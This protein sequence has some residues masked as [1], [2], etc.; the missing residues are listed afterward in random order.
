MW[1][2]T[3]SAY[4]YLERGV[5]YRCWNDGAI[6]KTNL[7]KDVLMG[8]AEQIIPPSFAQD[9]YTKLSIFGV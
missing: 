6:L 9:C 3:N 2:K 7:D 4:Y 1:F 5:V 8:F